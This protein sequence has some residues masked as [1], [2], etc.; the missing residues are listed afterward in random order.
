MRDGAAV[1]HV[2]VQL[3]VRLC[4]CSCFVITLSAGGGLGRVPWVFFS[5]NTL[6]L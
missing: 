5:F 2:C 3:C 4:G 1:A 6:V